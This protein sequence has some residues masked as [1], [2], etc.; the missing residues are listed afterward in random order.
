MTKRLASLLI[1]LTLVSAVAAGCGPRPLLEGMAIRPATISPNA[2]GHEDIA[3]IK[4]TIT[5]QANV[6]IYFL[7][8]EGERHDF[9]V[10]KRRSKGERTAYFGGV[11]ADRLLPDGVYTAVIEAT[12]ER[13]RAER[14]EST[15]TLIDGDKQ[16]LRIEGLSIWP[17]VFTPNRDGIT[18][19][20]TIGYNL[21]KEATRVEVYLLDAE[22]AKYPVAED[23]IREMGAP[24]AHEH[25]YDGGIDLGATPPADGDYTVVVEAEDAVGNREWVTGTLTIE[26]GGVPR[27]S[28]VNRAAEIAPSVV[29]LGETLTFTCTVKNEGTVPVRT[30][31]PEPGT[32]YSSLENYNTLGEFEEPGLFRIG[33]DFEGNSAGRSYPYRWQLGTD[34]ELTTIDTEIGPQK[35]LMPGQTVT[36]SGSVRIVEKTYTTEPYFWVGLL[37]EHVVIVQD[38]VDPVQVSIGF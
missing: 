16:P 31:G 5:R 6:S 38:R 22:G 26:G 12:D 35:Y 18:D 9:R 20:V 3:E 30:K 15:I 4:Y 19:R 29:P 25:D 24:G 36:V 8:A 28:I 2:D 13:G 27:V 37:H 1:L 11:I 14:V 33:L 7:D 23:K 10:N 21:S 34:D 17:K 32:E